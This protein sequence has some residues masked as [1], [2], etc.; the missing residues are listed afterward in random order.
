MSVR[1][2]MW[3]GPRNISTAMMRAFENRGDCVVSDEPLYA[4]FLQQT[5]ADH[6]L[7]DDI[8]AAGECDWRV[9]VDHLTGP[10]PDGKTLWYQKHMCHHLLPAMGRDWIDQLHNVLLIRNPAA[11]VA[12]YRRA[13]GTVSLD[14]IGL[15]QQA[16]LFRRLADQKG[17]PPLVIDADAF[18]AAPEAQLRALC[19][20]V[21]IDFSERMLSWPAGP[22][23]SDGIWAPHWYQAVWR[24]TGFA[25]PKSDD[26]DTTNAMDDEGR[27]VVDQAMPIYQQLLAQSLRC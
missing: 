26:D 15:P 10:I 3:S 14:E 22:R 20:N 25:S 11:V 17:Q 21:G 6:P 27:R 23:D 1:I 7:R 19:A 16:E 12:S 2:A 24:S 5:G 4:H 18:L 9:V 8:I 13:R